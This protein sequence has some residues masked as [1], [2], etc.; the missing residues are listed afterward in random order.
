MVGPG[1]EVG[2]ISDRHVGILNVCQEEIPGHAC[3]H[4]RW[5]TRH[6]VA[7][8]VDKDHIKDNF[9]L[10]EEMCRQTEMALFKKKLK[11]LK[12]KTNDCGREFLDRLLE[13]KEKWSLAYD[14]SG[15][16]HDF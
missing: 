16:W 15:W 11:A 14:E 5:C 8:L 9:K 10:F 1:R 13:S 3:V 7:N 2:V 6:L 12:L 4:H